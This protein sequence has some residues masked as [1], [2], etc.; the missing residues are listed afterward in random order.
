MAKTL[1][2]YNPTVN[3]GGGITPAGGEFPVAESHDILVDANGKRLDTK[4]DELDAQIGDTGETSVATQLGQKVA[5][6]D[7]TTGAPAST[8]TDAQVPSTKSMYTAL[9]TKP[10][11]TL[12]TAK[13]VSGSTDDQIPTSKA[14]YTGLAEK[15]NNADITTGAPASTNTDAQVPSTKSMYTALATKPTAALQT[16]AP[17]ASSTDA[18]VTSSKA[19]YTALQTKPTGTLSTA[20]PTS[21]STD[22]QIPTA[23]AV[24][25][26]LD[27]KINTADI[28]STVA[29]TG[30]TSA[31]KVP[32]ETAVREAIEAKTIPLEDSVP[33]AGDSPSA[34]TAPSVAATRTAIDA[35]IDDASQDFEDAAAALQTSYDTFTSE[36][37]AKIGDPTD[38][39]DD[40]ATAV[41]PRLK[42]AETDIDALSGQFLITDALTTA[43]MTDNTR[44][45]IYTG[46][47]IHVV[48]ATTDITDTTGNIIYKY[49]GA[50]SGNFTQNN[51]YKYDTSTSAYVAVTAADALDITVEGYSV[52]GTI[53]RPNY[54]FYYDTDTWK[55]G[56]NVSSVTVDSTLSIAGAAADAK[57]TGD[58]ITELSND[59]SN[60]SEYNV[61]Q[62]VKINNL[63]IFFNTNDNNS[64]KTDEEI[65]LTPIS[66]IRRRDFSINTDETV[67]VR[68]DINVQENEKYIVTAYRRSEY[69]GALQIFDSSNKLLYEINDRQVSNQLITI[70]KNGYLMSIN[71]VYNEDAQYKYRN[72]IAIKVKENKFEYDLFNYFKNKIKADAIDCEVFVNGILTNTYTYN[73]SGITYKIN[74][75]GINKYTINTHFFQVGFPSIFL[76]HN[77]IPISFIYPENTDSRFTRVDIEFICPAYVDYLL[78]SSN[79]IAPVVTRYSTSNL[80]SIID[81]QSDDNTDLSEIENALKQYVDYTN[82]AI[83]GT[84]VSQGL[85]YNVDTGK[86]IKLQVS[87]G[88]K[89]YAKT[90]RYSASY[91][92]YV[93][94]AS[95]DHTRI[96]ALFEES[97]GTYYHYIT[98]PENCAYLYINVPVSEDIFIQK[99]EYINIDS[100]IDQKLLYFNLNRNH[101][102]YNKKMVWFGTSIPEGGYAGSGTSYPS[103]VGKLLDCTV[104]NE[105]VG[106]S[107]ARCGVAEN[108]TED[109]PM[110]WTGMG[111]GLLRSLSMSY[112]ERKSIFDN[113]D[114]WKTKIN[115]L[116][117]EYNARGELD[118][119]RTWDRKLAKYLSGGDV[120]Q[121]DL[122]VFD[123]G[124]NDNYRRT[125]KN[126]CIVPEDITD[127]R[128]YIGAASFIFTKILEDNP[129]ARICIIGHYQNDDRPEISEAQLKLGD[130]WGIPVYDLW[131]HTHISE[132][133]LT[134]DG[135]QT[136]IHKLY[137][138][139]NLHPHTDKTGKTINMIANNIA[140]WI[141]S[142]VR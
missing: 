131:N 103:I 9:A 128:Y 32:S 126:I 81:D 100:Y 34:T 99:Y 41:W 39:A 42:N 37:D 50:T 115:G 120:G 133:I 93:L 110:G 24:Y 57:A 77:D 21:S 13:P 26:G 17:S 60:L 38:T 129:R 125:E 28:A 29:A 96:D 123:H 135:E 53:Y 121:V 83:A 119:S 92:N 51:L 130:I 87:P 40:A 104:Y 64:Y 69:H 7:I 112:A 117:D 102:W 118:L 142:S 139:D 62:D 66:G 134:I 122:Y 43:K 59:I 107:C 65:I 82:Y 14:V 140:S 94:I 138:P 111:V 23:K 56:S 74:N 3:I 114:Y 90:R 136:T 86:S 33:A 98:I 124:Y 44:F 31:T 1:S 72:M 22:T 73:D 19:I 88:E 71:G 141:D 4:L 68:Y 25:T 127:R 106:S 85:V 15:V 10:T 67:F 46:K 101:F 27:K 108:A 11:G 79:S 75:N 5:K 84:A 78:I 48:D 113:I 49:I 58:A 132:R 137:M 35:A 16:D 89:Y 2:N 91:P 52:A 8:N 55:Q 70:P 61:D 95:D 116:E 30:S 18:Q 80:L 36:V 97:N 47:E 109:D 63:E 76:F 6:S 45:Y 12:S 105:A 54:W 20:E